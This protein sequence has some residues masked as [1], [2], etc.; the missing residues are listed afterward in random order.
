MRHDARMLADL[1]RSV[2]AFLA[3]LLPAG[4]EIRFGAPDASWADSSLLAAFMYDIRETQPP[5]IDG[6]LIRDA[7]G[8]ATGWQPP[9]RHYQVSYLLTAW[10][11]TG[12]LG[13]NEHELLGAVLAGCATAGSIP[14]DCLHGTLA[15]AGEPV[16]LTC[17]GQEPAGEAVRIWPH[18]GVPAR[19]ALDLMVVAPVVP[20]LDAELA[21]V[22][23]TVNLGARHD[24][25]EARTGEKRPSRPERRITEG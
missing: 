2:A 18:L 13:T 14:D 16:P 9:V 8:H 22:V 25:E 19:T 11:D 21:P 10:T 6:T 5:A 23:R 24:L 12:P 17:A 15:E 1:D 7:D 4:T 3:R 20:P